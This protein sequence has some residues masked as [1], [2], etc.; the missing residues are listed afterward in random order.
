MELLHWMV[1][2]FWGFGCVWYQIAPFYQIWYQIREYECAGFSAAPFD[3]QR[4][5]IDMRGSDGKSVCLQ[6]GRPGFDPWLGK[7]LGEGN[8]TPL[9]YSAWKIPWTEEPDRLQSM[10][11]QR[12]GHDLASKHSTAYHL[13]KENRS[14]CHWR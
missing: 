2:S 14:H 4:Y 7:I 12:V 6:C 10:G 5:L 13:R 11:L 3:V 9:Q 8:G 1:C